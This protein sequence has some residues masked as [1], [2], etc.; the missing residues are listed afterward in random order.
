L[1][2]R[3]IFVHI[4][5]LMIALS[6]WRKHICSYWLPYDCLVNMAICVNQYFYYCFRRY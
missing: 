4:E 2:I 6:T 3:N 1:T 5:Y